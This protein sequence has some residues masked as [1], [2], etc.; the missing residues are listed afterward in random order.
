MKC[1]AETIFNFPL[2]T[3]VVLFKVNDNLI[4]ALE[5]ECLHVAHV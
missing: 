4:M 3:G 5:Y 1:N 2:I